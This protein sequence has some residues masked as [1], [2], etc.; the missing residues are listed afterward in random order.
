[1]ILVFQVQPRTDC[2]NLKRIKKKMFSFLIFQNKIKNSRSAEKKLIRK[3]Y[4]HS[5]LLVIVLN[6][7]ILWLA[8]YALRAVCLYL[9]F[10]F[11]AQTCG[12]VSY[13]LKANPKE[14]YWTCVGLSILFS[15]I[16]MPPNGVC[17][18]GTQAIHSP[19]PARTLSICYNFIFA[20][21][22]SFFFLWVIKWSF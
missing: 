20:A 12:V 21:F 5:Y 10:S 8:P 16:L 4:L 18:I 17:A 6:N 3:F 13:L 15:S 22:F 9:Q 11:I 19:G 2:K 1:V 7:M 14:M